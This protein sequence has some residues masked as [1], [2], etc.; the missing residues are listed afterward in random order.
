MQS[1][2][3]STDGSCITINSSRSERV[4]GKPP[5]TG[6][7]ISV[8]GDAK[9]L[10]AVIRKV[11]ASSTIT[12]IGLITVKINDNFLKSENFIK[13]YDRIITNTAKTSRIIA[14]W[15]REESFA[16]AI[17]EVISPASSSSKLS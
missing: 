17:S 7:S 9:K 5:K 2:I 3:I 1:T 16:S 8:S 11:T 4:S 10:T 14:S 15:L 12:I 13:Y 6:S